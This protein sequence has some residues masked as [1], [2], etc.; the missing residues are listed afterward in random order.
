MKAEP[1]TDTFVITY[2]KGNNKAL[3]IFNIKGETKDIKTDIPD[4]I[5]KIYLMIAI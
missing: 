1:D 4:G 3:G 5:Y 2:C